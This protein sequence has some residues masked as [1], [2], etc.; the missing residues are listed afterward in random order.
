MKKSKS[1]RSGLTLLELMMALGIVVLLLGAS[2]ASMRGGLGSADS[3]SLA[4]VAVEQFRLARQS[5][6]STQVPV[7]V[8]LPTDNGRTPICQSVYFATGRSTAHVDK[9]VQFAK[10]HSQACLFTGAWSLSSGSFVINPALAGQS[11]S[12]F[13][14]TQWLSNPNLGFDMKHDYAFVF[15]PDGSLVTNGVP[16]NSNTGCYYVIAN[17]GATYSP[18]SAPAGPTEPGPLQGLAYFSPT[19]IARPWAIALTPSGSVSLF[20]G[21]PDS[22]AMPAADTIAISSPAQS[23]TLTNLPSLSVN[24]A[25]P[26]GVEIQPPPTDTTGLPT[27]VN[28]TLAPGQRVT[29]SV[30]CTESTGR[31]VYVS[32]RAQPGSSNSPITQP[33]VGNFSTTGAER[34]VWDAQNQ[35]WKS[36]IDWICPRNSQT[37]DEWTFVPSFGPSPTAM[38]ANP[39][40]AQDIQTVRQP[41]I[42]AWVSDPGINWGPG[43]YKLIQANLDGTGQHVVT[44][45]VVNYS[46]PS[47]EVFSCSNDGSTFAIVHDTGFATGTKTASL[48]ANVTIPDLGP[49]ASVHISPQGDKVAY[50]RGYPQNSVEIRNIDGSQ[51]VSIYTDGSG[52]PPSNGAPPSGADRIENLSWSPDGARLALAVS[53]SGSGT[54]SVW[55]MNAD[56]SNRNRIYDYTSGASGARVDWDRTGRYVFIADPIVQEAK[57]YDT[58]ANSLDSSFFTSTSSNYYGSSTRQFTPDNTRVYFLDWGGQNLYFQNNSALA[59]VNQVPIELQQDPVLGSSRVLAFG[60]SNP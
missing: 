31:D 46:H 54:G 33:S 51:A 42:W 10:D 25:V 41:Q 60:L 30:N 5:A 4:L 47:D 58:V 9:A 59:P 27:G 7:A 18:S 26:G 17:A 39:S 52:S 1:T 6:I 2:I 14:V 29:L 19:A 24:V 36:T 8:V 49:A 13:N 40:A 16:F 22:T 53:Y 38:V 44:S 11:S 55:T 35:M 45:Q 48:I 43:V 23:P 34:M 50:A 20:S 56:G 21:L 3:H 32:W 28:T 57:R 12:A 15:Q 37:G